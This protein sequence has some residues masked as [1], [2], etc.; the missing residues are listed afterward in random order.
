VSGIVHKITFLGNQVRA[1]HGP[2][3]DYKYQV[4]RSV[5]ALGAKFLQP[6]I[7]ELFEGRKPFQSTSDLGTFCYYNIKRL[8]VLTQVCPSHN[9][10]L[11]N[12][13]V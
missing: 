10:K 4:T 12:E 11:M 5:F 2:R 13:S 3:K 1:S 7:T 8:G 9:Y 6:E